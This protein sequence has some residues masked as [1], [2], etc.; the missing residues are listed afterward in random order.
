MVASW[1][2]VMQP[3]YCAA[4]GEAGLTLQSE[5]FGRSIFAK[6]VIFTEA[7]RKLPGGDNVCLQDMRQTRQGRQTS[8]IGS[9]RQDRTFTGDDVNDR[10]WS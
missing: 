1:E 3:Y 10:I 9:F 4:S 8:Q 2:G 6:G 7:G 5:Q